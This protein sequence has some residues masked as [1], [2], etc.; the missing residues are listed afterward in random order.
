MTHVLI[1]GG[2]IA[3][4]VTAMALR[5]AGI[6]ATV[7]E[8]YPVGA[9]DV[10]AFLVLFN[11]GLEALRTIGAHQPVLDAAFPAG[12]V[13]L[14][15]AEGE[16]IAERPASG[17]R[18]EDGAGVLGPHTLKRA[19]LY[20]VL[21]DEAARRGVDVQ[22]G[23][24]LTGAETL[25]DGRV[26]ARFADGT[27]ATGDLLLGA[28]GLHSTVRG[29]LDPHAPRPRHTGQIT[30]CGYAR[31]LSP[32]LSPAVGTYRMLHGKRAFLGCTRAP[33]GEVWWFANTPGEEMSREELAAVTAGEWRERLRALFAEDGTP[34]AAVVGASGEG[35][36]GSNAYDI[37]RTPVWHSGPLAVLGD[38]AHAAAPNAGQGASMA[39]ED[40]VVLAKCLRDLPH[41]EGAFAAYEHLRRERVER[42][43]R[44]SAQLNA[45]AVH[46]PERAAPEK[47]GPGKSV[48]EE[49][50]PEERAAG[51]RAAGDRPPGGTSTWLTHY[52]I[53]W[54][55]PVAPA[56]L[57]RP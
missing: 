2:G 28:D 52:R 42:L 30:V 16:L 24:R 21:H 7:Y 17:T 35:I 8:A 18:D 41:P 46:G 10:G 13:E 26:T 1:I 4:P 44:Q 40:G 22:H 50:V 39:I 57:N 25:P 29:L 45:H 55:E 37:A 38:A 36:V 19:A 15:S 48:P 9:D 53:A 5:K 14:F 51:E 31:G 43:V 32:E 12:S 20:R 56:P 54:D 27:S 33:D 11:N 23:K 34:A 3:G 47:A 6:G 49:G